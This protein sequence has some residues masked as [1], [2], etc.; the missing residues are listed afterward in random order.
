M[1]APEKV[2]EFC[3]AIYHKGAT[4][5]GSFILDCLY[6]TNYH[7]DIDVYDQR[8]P[9]DTERSGSGFDVKGQYNRFTTYLCQNGFAFFQ[10]CLGNSNYVR[11]FLPRSKTVVSQNSRD[12]FPISRTEKNQIQIVT[13]GIAPSAPGRSTVNKCILASYDLDICKVGF[14]GRNLYVRSWLKLIYRFDHMVPNTRFLLSVYDASWVEEKH[15]MENRAQKY[16]ERGFHI[17]RHPLTELIDQHIYRVRHKNCYF[18]TGGRCPGCPSTLGIN[19]L[20]E[21]ELGNINL[22]RFSSSRWPREW[23]IHIGRSLQRLDPKNEPS[24]K[25]T[26]ASNLD[27]VPEG[28]EFP[29]EE[30]ITEV[31]METEEGF[32]SYLFDNDCGHYELKALIEWFQCTS[33]AKKLAGLCR[34][35]PGDE[36]KM[37]DIILFNRNLFLSKGGVQMT[38]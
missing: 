16:R 34:Y 19:G 3:E 12:I 21:I 31:E 36:K 28:F 26:R 30:P 25:F 35:V 10:P 22:D 8:N 2:D 20:R 38:P 15:I 9:E 6:E 13:S 23:I 7:G 5:A 14:D 11:N 4:I 33:G 37:K 18:C 29:Q 17:L 24:D 32:F 27:K 1:V